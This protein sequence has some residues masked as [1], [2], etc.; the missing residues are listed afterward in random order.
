[1][2]V[3]EQIAPFIQTGHEVRA[4]ESTGRSSTY[5]P[6]FVAKVARAVSTLTNQHDGGSLIVGIDESNPE[7]NGLDAATSAEWV[8]FNTVVD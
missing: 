1:M 7:R 6:A 8:D 2:L 3:D 4:V 5:D